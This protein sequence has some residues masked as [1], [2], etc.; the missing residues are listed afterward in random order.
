MNRKDREQID[1]CCESIVSKID[2]TKLLPKLLENKVYNRDDVNIPRWSKNL[3][4]QN[5]IKDVLLTIKTR[6]P[7]A[8]KNLILSLRQSNHEDV[9]DI[10][11][12][13]N[14]TSSN[15]KQENP[16]DHHIFSD[17]FFSEPLTIEVCR[18]TKFLDCEYD[19]IERY[20]MRSKPRGLVLIITNIYYELSYEKPRFSAKHDNNNL[21]KLFEEMGFTVVTYLNL[22]GQAMKDIIKE[23]SKRDDL[24]KVDSCFVI[25][26][27][28]GMEDE[29]SNTEIQGTDYHIAS[30]QANY[31]KV[32]CTEVC[33]YFTAEACPQL[34]EKPK[35]F[36]F[37]LC[38]GKK[39]QNGVIHSRI[40][41]D[42]CAVK[43]TNEANIEIPHIQTIRN[44]SD[45]LIVQSTLPGYVSYR[46]SKTGSWFIQILCKIFM[47]HAHKN[48]VQDLF[49]MIDAELKILR[50]TNHECQTSS[51]QSL[52]F[53][54]HCYLNP[55]LFMES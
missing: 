2:L 39:K 40:T 23:F 37:Q 22:T 55:G 28:H 16:L 41:T 6:G 48:H 7:N 54:K 24:N 8:F 21:K 38:R 13:Q 47:N 49:N 25:V 31:E 4:A 50:T 11:E 30:R 33:D 42:S 51:V 53:N 9:A 52:G 18:A 46:D 26:T 29:E 3:G 43:S 44:Y 19:L 35:I 15:T 36:I 17:E 45:M 12:K 34:A 20:P 1:Y 10:L 27:S 14:N 5:T 32:L